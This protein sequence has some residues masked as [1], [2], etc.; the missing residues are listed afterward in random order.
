MGLILSFSKPA[1]QRA[2]LET[3]SRTNGASTGTM[4]QN[5]FYLTAPDGVS[6]LAAPM[7]VTTARVYNGATANG[8]FAVDL[9]YSTDLVTATKLGTTG[10][11]AQ[12]G[13]NAIQTAAFT[14]TVIVPAFAYVYIGFSMDSATGTYLRATTFTGT[15]AKP[16][17][18][19]LTASSYN[20]AGPTYTLNSSGQA[21]IPWVEVF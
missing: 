13:T 3:V 19:S 7:A 17:K 1:V 20:P 15:Q 2:F 21:V 9:W 5:S 8:N 10:S 4:T 11:V 16:F 18:S 6:Q 12:S 14:A